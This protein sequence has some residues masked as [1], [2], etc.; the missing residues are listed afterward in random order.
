[1]LSGKD[2][3]AQQMIKVRT[4]ISAG[5][6]DSFAFDT[7]LVPQYSHTMCSVLAVQTDDLRHQPGTNV[8]QANQT[9]TGD[10]EPVV[11]LRSKARR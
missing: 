6:K 11:D 3:P 10:G 1:M 5:D 8:F 7:A 2:A 4:C 9:D